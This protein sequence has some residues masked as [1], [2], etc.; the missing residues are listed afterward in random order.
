MTTKVGPFIRFINRF[1]TAGRKVNRT[2][3]STELKQG[4]EF[5][6]RRLPNGSIALLKNGAKKS[7]IENTL[8][9]FKRNG[10]EYVKHSFN[11]KDMLGKIHMWISAE[12]NDYSTLGQNIYTK[13]L[14]KT[15]NTNSGKLEEKATRIVSSEDGV[16]INVLSKKQRKSVFPTTAIGK[17]LHPA[18]YKKTILP[19]EDIVYT[20][21][22]LKP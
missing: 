20:E 4:E 19:N 18:V 17:N 22:Y 3:K 16:H 15:F 21:K 9:L 10:Q 2:V 7:L 8:F 1:S 13:Q 5:Y 14:Q 11:L 6:Q 12:R